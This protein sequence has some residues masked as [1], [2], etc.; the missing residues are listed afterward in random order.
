VIDAI[1]LG[2]MGQTREIGDV[3]AFLAS[4]SASFMTASE[5]FIDGGLTVSMMK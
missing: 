2:R 5:V 1:P 3:V 4:D